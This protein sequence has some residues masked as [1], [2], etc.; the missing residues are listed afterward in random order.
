M[1]VEREKKAASVKKMEAY[2]Y[3]Q[4][5]DPFGQ[6]S[7]PW[8][9]SVFNSLSNRERIGQLFMVAAYS[10]RDEKHYREIDSLVEK[11]SIGGL[12]FMQ[13]G[14]QRQ[15]NLTNRWQKK[16]R[17]PLMLS[18]D[19]EWGLAMRLDSVTRFPK[20]MTL[21]ALPNDSL[22]Y[23]VGKE[24]A[25]SCKRIGMQVNFGPVA[26]VNNNPANPVIN[27]RS[28][29]ERRE[30]VASRAIAYMRGMQDQQARQT[31][32]LRHSNRRV[33]AAVINKHDFGA[34]QA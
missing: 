34:V 12:I 1:P 7:Y 24:I 18:M 11:Y 27:M 16:A 10:N 28:F 30:L 4:A 25:L 20:Q 26:D 9:D 23:E 29:G 6:K 15:V 31:R 5:A 32:G 3:S 33:I 17:V 19:A 14:P 13:G 8:A 2:P 21:G 22:V